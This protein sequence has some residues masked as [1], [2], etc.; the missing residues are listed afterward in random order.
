MLVGQ[1]FV[2]FRVLYQ[3]AESATM[4]SLLSFRG[5]YPQ[6]RAHFVN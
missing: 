1:L 3:V 5:E 6:H 4:R 2:I